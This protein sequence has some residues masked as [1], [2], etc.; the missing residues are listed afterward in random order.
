M[1][2]GLT[3]SV[4][5]TEGEKEKDDFAR[6]K[7]I[8]AK[9]GMHDIYREANGC[10]ESDEKI[11]SVK[12]VK[13]KPNQVGKPEP[14]VVTLD[15]QYEAACIELRDVRQVRKMLSNAKGLRDSEWK[16]VFL[17]P[18]LTPLDREYGKRLRAERDQLNSALSEQAKAR[19]RYGVRGD[20]VVKIFANSSR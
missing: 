19:F 3:P 5:E 17:A 11:V 13:S 9:C 18:D 1:V 14:I 15:E 4:A 8:L 6:V 10:S 7:K 16:G 20:Q 12:R 2:F